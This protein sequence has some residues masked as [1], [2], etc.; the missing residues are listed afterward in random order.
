MLP[1]FGFLPHRWLVDV[2]ESDPPPH[3]FEKD[4]AHLVQFSFIA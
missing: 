1:L 4:S 3:V 2:I